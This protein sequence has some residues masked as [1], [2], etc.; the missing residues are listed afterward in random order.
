[1]GCVWGHVQVKFVACSLDFGRCGLLVVLLL[2]G[3]K[4][5]FV[6]LPVF[7]VAACR[8]NIIVGIIGRREIV[9]L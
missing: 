7:I 1:M 5:G 2:A 4:R 6:G 9:V 8:I 3:V